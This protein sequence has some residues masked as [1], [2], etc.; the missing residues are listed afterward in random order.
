[1]RLADFWP[2]TDVDHMRCFITEAESAAE[3]VF[4]A[5]HQPMKL[6]RSFFGVDLESVPQTEEDVLNALLLSKPPSGTLILPIVGDSGVGKSHMI[7]WL[8][9]RLRLLP[10]SNIR[11][12]VRIPKSSSLK[13]VLRLILQELPGKKYDELRQKIEKAKTPPDRLEATQTLRA[14][15]L[16]ALEIAGNEASTRIRQG[17]AEP[18]DK[19]RKNH[20]NKLCL[21]ALLEDPGIRDHF[22]SHE[23]EDE[24]KWGVLTRI[25]ERCLHGSK[26]GVSGPTENEFLPEDFE[27]IANSA[28]LDISVLAQA[29]RNYILHLRRDPSMMADAIRFLNEV[30][31][32]ARSG[33]IDMGGIS[34]TELFI[35]IRINLLEDGMELVL[36]IEDFAVLAGIQAP[37]LDAMIREGIRN[38]KQE[39]CVMRTALAVTEGRLSEETVR[40]RAQA[41]W[42]IESKPFGSEEDAIETYVNFVGG[43]L[44]AARWGVSQLSKMFRERI[45][46][47]NP[48]GWIRC[49]FDKHQDDMDETEKNQLLKFGFSHSGNYPLFPFNR[50]AIRQM[51]RQYLYDRP[52]N[53]F[54]FDPRLLINRLL[55]SGFSKQSAEPRSLFIR[56]IIAW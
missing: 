10:D 13:G 20:C 12:I 24:R 31:E 7:R 38:G 50:E 29:T 42:K 44:N 23:G 34:L 11:H 35:D 16:I 21:I 49:F 55:I 18:S 30:L 3:E 33:L 1:M 56:Q 8:D 2:A 48:T 52:T 47:A 5:V 4:L 43:Y 32:T 41:R 19:F 6:T 54:R 28:N 25:S 17:N 46:Q 9:A 51:A 37:L 45:D 26:C 40:T 39:L 53:T 36:L 14:K 22:T 15:L 27:F